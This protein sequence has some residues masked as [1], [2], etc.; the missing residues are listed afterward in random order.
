MKRTQLTKE[1]SRALGIG[2][3]IGFIALSLFT[4]LVG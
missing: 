3:V 1:D 4:L 2:F